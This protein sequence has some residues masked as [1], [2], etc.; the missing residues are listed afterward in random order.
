MPTYTYACTACNHS[1]DVR[2]SFSDDPL[3]DCP[4]CAQGVGR[5]RKVIHPVGISFKGSGFYKTDSRASTSSPSNGS[6]SKDGSGS[7]AKEPSSA[8]AGDSSKETGSS[9]GSGS[10]STSAVS[11]SS[12]GSS[13]SSTSS[14]SGGA[15]AS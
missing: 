4:E 13:A 2:Q 15:K 7:P 6:G 14:T 8:P 12:S 10:S 5:L 9:T 1:F 11:P 3:T